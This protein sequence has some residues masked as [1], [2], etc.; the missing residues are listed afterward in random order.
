MAY[1]EGSYPTEL[2]NKVGHIKLIQDPMIQR[3][4][5]AFQ[6]ARPAVAGILPRVSGTIDLELRSDLRQVVTIDGGH[7][8]VPNIARPERQI[9]FVQVAVQ[10]IKT[11]TIEFL[12]NNPMADPREVQRALGQFTHHILAALPIAGL[13]MEGLT[14]RQSIREALHRFLNHYELYPALIY[15]VFR[16]WEASP[17]DLPAMDCL[18]CGHRFDL[19]RGALAFRCPRCQ[20]DH[21]LS[22]YLGL[23][24]GADDRS[25]LEAVSGLRTVL[26][27]LAMFALIVRFRDHPRVISRTLFLLDGPLLLRAQLSRLVEPIRAFLSYQARRGSPIHLVGIEKS[28]ELRAFADSLSPSFIEA[29]Q[30]FI[31]DARFLVE[32]INGQSFDASTYRN[33]VN[34]GAKVIIRLGRDHVFVA[35][36]PT[37]EYRQA[38]QASD[39][40]GFEQS[41]RL[42]ARLLSYRYPNAL[43]PIV[44]ANTAASISNQPSGSILAQFVDRLLH[45]DT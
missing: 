42:L 26:E 28:G 19:M 18:E 4:I 6:D 38:P 13:H 23:S 7:Q 25:T 32:D 20:H 45:G 1:G 27:A 16:Q 17:T 34:Y 37:G 8:A 2:A 41:M 22:D 14:L 12:R 24:D 40:L 35:N 43:I 9:G 3:I 29:G 39:L 31:P 33:R 5:E 11:E 21:R 36:V 10:L 15:L 44:L 30:F